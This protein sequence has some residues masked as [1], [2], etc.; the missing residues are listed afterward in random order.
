MQED[1]IRKHYEPRID[2]NAESF[3]IADWG[4]AASQTKRF[5]ALIELV[6]LTGRSL[7]DVGCGTGDL[8]AFL[9]RRGLGVDYLGVDLLEKMIAEAHR[10]HPAAAFECV[11]PFDPTS[12]AG[13]SFNVVFASGVFNLDTGNS[14]E[15][16]PGGIRRLLDLADEALVFNLLHA[17]AETRH[18]H[19]VYYTPDQITRLLDPLA[20]DC[21]IVDDY[22]PN[23]F[24]VI[25]RRP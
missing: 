17:R 16:L 12:L 14:R 4:D 19:C 10:R 6:D 25:C 21:R 23:D 1:R 8:W 3:E 24:T 9:A 18:D 5:E 13:R 22:L 7:L 20:C 2:P 15:F 11:D